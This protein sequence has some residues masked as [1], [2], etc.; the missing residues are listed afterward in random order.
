[1]PGSSH[2]CEAEV[3]SH[4]STPGS[5]EVAAIADTEDTMEPDLKVD[6]EKFDNIELRWFSIFYFLMNH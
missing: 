4:T 2:V 6:E 3:Q 5:Q 1:M